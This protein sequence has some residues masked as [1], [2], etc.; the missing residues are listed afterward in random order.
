MILIT[1]IKD[2]VWEFDW[3]HVD[4]F[5]SQKLDSLLTNKWA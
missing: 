4:A 3:L 2:N 5:D 1:N